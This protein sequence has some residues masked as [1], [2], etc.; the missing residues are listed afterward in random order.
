[1]HKYSHYN[2]ML[3]L[4]NTH[5]GILMMGKIDALTFQQAK[6]ELKLSKWSDMCEEAVNAKNN[7]QYE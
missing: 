5:R 1:M 3:G 6:Q 2:R 7:R 4:T